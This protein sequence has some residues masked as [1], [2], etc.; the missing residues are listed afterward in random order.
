MGGSG[1]R[2]NG[3]RRVGRG[4]K[5]ILLEEKEKRAGEAMTNVLGVTMRSRKISAG[6]GMPFQTPVG[7]ESAEALRSNFRLVRR[8][9]RG[10]KPNAEDSL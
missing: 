4:H 10:P 7:S 1:G 6:G 8:R 5:M 2:R 9:G 3:R